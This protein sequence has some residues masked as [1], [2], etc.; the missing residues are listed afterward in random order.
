MD[1]DLDSDPDPDIFISDLQRPKNI[2]ILRIRIR[3]T[4][5][6]YRL[7]DYT[8]GLYCQSCHWGNTAPSPA[9]IVHNWD[10]TKREVGSWGTYGFQETC[11]FRRLVVFIPFLAAVKQNA[12]LFVSICKR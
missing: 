8:G 2:W 5:F 9:R 3:K 1:P 12:R 11:F 7:C 6:L 10:F 4:G